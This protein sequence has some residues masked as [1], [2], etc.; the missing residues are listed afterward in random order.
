[1][2]KKII[3]FRS[4]DKRE[5]QDLKAILSKLNGNGVEIEY[6]RE[7]TLLEDYINLPFVEADNGACFF[8]IRSINSFIE[9]TIQEGA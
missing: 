8:G 7:S 2:C 9:E 3:V 4:S 5:N 1:M 6:V